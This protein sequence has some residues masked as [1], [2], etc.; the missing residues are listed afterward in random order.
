MTNSSG[1]F[2]TYPLP[3]RD[4]LR[5]FQDRAEG[6]PDLFIRFDY[7][8]HLDESRQAIAKLLNVPVEEIVFVPN[9]TTAINTVLRNLIFKEGDKIAYFST[10]Y[11]ACEKTVDYITET[12]PAES[13]K[14]EYTYPVSD[15]WMVQKFK[16][17]LHAEKVKIAIFDTVV[18]V[19]GLRMPFERLTEACRE[20]GV[21]SLIDGAHGVGHIPLDLGALNADFT[22]SNAH[23]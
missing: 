11:G 6:T 17:L 15:D 4:A 5:T 8:R 16:D 20:A 12:T 18:S 14:V 7:P 3:V 10:I 22:V 13:V 9:A 21:L 1:S 23:K 2:G 19:P